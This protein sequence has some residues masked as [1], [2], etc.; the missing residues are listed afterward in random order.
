VLFPLERTPL[1]PATPPPILSGIRDE[2]A[3]GSKGI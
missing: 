1:I 3:P 2:V